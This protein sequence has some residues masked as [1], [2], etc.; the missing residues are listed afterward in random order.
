MSDLSSDASAVL[1]SL[2]ERS[3][4]SFAFFARNVLALPL[5][6]ERCLELAKGSAP[7]S[8]DE[9]SALLLWMELRAGVC[10]N[11][12]DYVRDLLPGRVA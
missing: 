7:R 1:S 9:T 5:T 3:C 4:S 10:D 8:V 6:R 12:P 11:L 2:R